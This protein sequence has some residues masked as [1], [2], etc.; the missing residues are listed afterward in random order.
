MRFKTLTL[1]AGAAAIL[2]LPLPV[3]ARD[4]E[5]SANKARTTR[6]ARESAS[7]WF[8]RPVLVHDSILLGQYVIEHDK[9][10]QARGEPCTHIYRASDHR[11]VLAFHCTHLTRPASD[12][13]T[14]T[15]V[16]TGDSSG[17]RKLTAFQFAGDTAAHA[18]PIGR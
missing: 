7:V 2:A 6:P 5:D 15:L 1:I 14:V 10:R 4:C 9:Y 16:P 8:A 17:P 3:I 13:T 18:V 11:L 12:R